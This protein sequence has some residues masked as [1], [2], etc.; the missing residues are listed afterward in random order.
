MSLSRSIASSYNGLACLKVGNKIRYKYLD[1]KCCMGDP[2]ENGVS[3]EFSSSIHIQKLGYRQLLIQCPENGL[4][5][6][7]ELLNLSG[8]IMQSQIIRE[9][10]SRIELRVIPGYLSVSFNRR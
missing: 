8:Q 2:I 1:Y 5:L 3:K 4:P 9:A 7:F 10:E 6:Q